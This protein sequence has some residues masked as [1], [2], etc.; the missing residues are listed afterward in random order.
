MGSEEQRCS[1]KYLLRNTERNSSQT[2][3]K[4]KIGIKC[5][6][7]RVFEDIERGKTLYVDIQKKNIKIIPVVNR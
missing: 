3:L 5:G 6:I 1:E 7:G 4:N 2:K